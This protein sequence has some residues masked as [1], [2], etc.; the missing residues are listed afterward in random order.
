M[1][2]L[3]KGIWY[4]AD[5]HRYRVR[6][7]HNKVAYLKGYYKT[8]EEAKAAWEELGEHLARVPKLPRRKRGTPLEAPVPVNSLSGTAQAIRDRQA[9]DPDVLKRKRRGT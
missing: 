5:K 6:R 7:Y 8:Y 2:K 1:P 3:P 9:F 4:E